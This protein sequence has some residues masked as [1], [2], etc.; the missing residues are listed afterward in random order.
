MDAWAICQ[1]GTKQRMKCHAKKQHGPSVRLVLS[2]GYSVI[3]VDL[4]RLELGNP[5]YQAKHSTT[6]SDSQNFILSSADEIGVKE[7]SKYIQ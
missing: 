2:R 5:E 4:G 1:A 3:L 6:E 7:K